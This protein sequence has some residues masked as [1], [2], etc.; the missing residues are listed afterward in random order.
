MGET[1]D[2]ATHGARFN[3]GLELRKARRALEEKLV[4]YAAE[5]P[6]LGYRDLCKQFTLSLGAVSKIMRRRKKPKASRDSFIVQHEYG[7]QKLTTVATVT[8]RASVEHKRLWL[9]ER[10]RTQD[11]VEGD[12]RS[13]LR[14]V[15]H[16][17]QSLTRWRKRRMRT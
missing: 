2:P 6:E 11:I 5:H 7:G 4:A 16:A 15:E 8:G 17:G 10:Y 9:A 14:R 1:S 12:D 13:I 3:F